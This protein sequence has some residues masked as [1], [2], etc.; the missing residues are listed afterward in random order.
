MPRRSRD[1][2][3]GKPRAALALPCAALRA[4]PARAPRCAPLTQLAEVTVGEAALGLLEHGPRPHAVPPPKEGRPHAKV[5]PRRG[6]PTARGPPPRWLL[7]RRRTGVRRVR[8]SRE[9][10][11][12]LRRGPRRGGDVPSPRVKRLQAVAPQTAQLD[13]VAGRHL[14]LG[15]SRGQPAL[16]KIR[17]FVSTP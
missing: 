2:N 4:L 16:V 17:P 12:A 10:R 8:R 5:R 7:L 1:P 13:K 11:G 14:A 6:H 9:L 15:D 3:H